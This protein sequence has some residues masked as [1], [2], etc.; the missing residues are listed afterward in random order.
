MPVSRQPEKSRYRYNLAMASAAVRDRMLHM[1]EAAERAGR[2]PGAIELTLSGYLPTTD[3]AA[4]AEGE[5]LGAHRMVLSAPIVDDLDQVC[6]AMTRFA[7][8]WGLDGGNGRPALATEVGR[9]GGSTA[10]DAPG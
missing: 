1:R 6:E 7:D 2:D 8:R 9:P 3:E 4:I 10:R 5:A